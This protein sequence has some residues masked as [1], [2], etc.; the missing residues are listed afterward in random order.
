[1]SFYIRYRDGRVQRHI[2]ETGEFVDCDPDEPCTRIRKH[3]AAGNLIEGMIIM[4]AELGKKVTLTKVMFAPSVIGKIPEVRAFTSGEGRSAAGIEGVASMLKWIAD[5]TEGDSFE[6]IWSAES[7]IRGDDGGEL[8]YCIVVRE[9]GLFYMDL[10]D[11]PLDPLDENSPPVC[12]TLESAKA[13]CEKREALLLSVETA[14]QT[15]PRQN[16]NAPE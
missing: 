3:D 7:S 8:V 15:D 4:P 13:W 10:T 1:M 12:S 14:R 9:D 2:W 11:Y 16:A 5:R 6:G